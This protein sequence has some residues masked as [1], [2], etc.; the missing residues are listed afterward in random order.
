MWLIDYEYSGNNDACFELG[1]T[2]TECDFDDEQVEAY[3][4]A[5]FGDVDAGDLARVRLQSLVCAVRLVAVGRHPGR[6]QPDRL[7]LP[8]LGAW[9]AS[10][11]RTRTFRG[12][13]ASSGC[14][15]M[16]TR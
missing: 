2:A 15:R 7:R 11:R 9:S 14:W 12:P 8:R 4:A 6:G 16:S 5:Y 1:N 13:G 3:V 10:T